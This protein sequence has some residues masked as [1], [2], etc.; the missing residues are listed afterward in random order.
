[1]PPKAAVKSKKETLNQILKRLNLVE[2]GYYDKQQYRNDDDG[3]EYLSFETE[4]FPGCCGIVV[5]YEL[6]WEDISIKDAV[7][8][9]ELSFDRSTGSLMYVTS[10]RQGE[11]EKALKNAEWIVADRCKNPNTGSL[12]TIWTK[13]LNPL[14]KKK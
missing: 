8:I 1:M 11:I 12:L 9:M 10:N 5:V 7:T 14:R 3:T 2:D 13:A 4:E 6:E